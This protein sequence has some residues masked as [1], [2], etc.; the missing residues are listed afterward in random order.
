MLKA[1]KVLYP[2]YKDTILQYY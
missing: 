2:F 1:F